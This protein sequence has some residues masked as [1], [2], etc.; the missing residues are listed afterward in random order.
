MFF[1]LCFF[2]FIIVAVFLHR[3]AY[4]FDIW[5]II[6]LI[7]IA[8]SG[9]HI[10]KHLRFILTSFLVKQSVHYY[11]CHG[12]LQMLNVALQFITHPYI[13]SYYFKIAR[14]F[15]MLE[16]SAT[17]FIS[18]NYYTKRWVNTVKSV[19]NYVSLACSEYVVKPGHWAQSWFGND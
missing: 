16:L 12:T 7:I 3:I 4:I 18:H 8:I 10:L 15:F 9:V 19:S 14:M 6:Y 13:N 1:L 17:R 5:L 11:F 2:L